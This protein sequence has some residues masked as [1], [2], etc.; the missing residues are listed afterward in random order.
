MYYTRKESIK[1][2]KKGLLLIILLISAL[3]LLGCDQGIESITTTSTS[4]LTTEFIVLDYM[5]QVIPSNVALRFEPSGY[6]S[7]HTWR[8]HGAPVFTPDGTEMYWSKYIT[9]SDTVE[10]W[11]TQQE[12]GV[13]LPPQKLVI[14]GIDGAINCPV[15]VSGDEGLYFLNVDGIDF[16]IYRA[17][18]SESGWQNPISIDLPIPDGKKLGWSFT[19]AENRNIYFSLWSLDGS[20]STKIYRSIYMNGSYNDLEELEALNTGTLGTGGPAIAKDES[21]II[22]D[23]L[24]VGG[25]SQHDLYIS[26]KNVDG[27]FSA[28]INLG[29]QINSDTEDSS[30][31]LSPD[32]MYLFFTTVKTSDLGYNPYWIKMDEIDAF[33]PFLD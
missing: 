8:W 9:E 11:Y 21:Y 28:P 18:R 4:S 20:E 33:K 7:D 31:T 2:G 30:A 6:L 1:M 17:T 24:I 27:D 12:N 16:T 10:T 23:S 13:W 26:Y 5:N 22:F 19:I 29:P 32:G 15:F 25:T 14:D 3:L